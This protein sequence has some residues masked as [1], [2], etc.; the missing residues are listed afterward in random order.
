MKKGFFLSLKLAIFSILLIKSSL[1]AI[2]PELVSV[3][4]QQVNEISRL[5][6]VFDNDD[7]RADR[8]HLEDEKQ[9]ILNIPNIQATQRVLRGFNTSEFSG[10]IVFVQ[11]YKKENGVR[12]AIQLRDNVRS[13][14]QREPNRVI[15]RVENRF[16]VFSERQASESESF[17][18]R[19]VREDQLSDGRGRVHVPESDSV[20]DILENLTKSGRKRYVGK[21]ISLNVREVTVEDVLRMI[22]QASGFN[23]ILDQDIRSL[24][25]I[26]LNVNNIP[27]DQALDTVLGLN[28][29]V[30]KRN[31]SILMVTTFAKETE[32]QR[33]E[34]A[35]RQ[36]VER[37]EPLVTRVFP[38]SFTTTSE[39]RDILSEYLTEDRGTMSED[40]RTNSLIVRDVPDIIEK[41]RKI[42]EVLDT[43]TPQVLIESKIVEVTE[44]YRKEIGLR[45]GV[46]FSYDPVSASL[47]DNVGP[48]FAF[49][50]APVAAGDSFM[51]LTI[52]QF[53][54]LAD[55]RFSL[56]LLETEQKGKIISSPK[57]VTENKKTATISTT[58][59]RFFSV[60]T[61]G[62]DGQ[63][64]TSDIVE[65]EAVLN[66][67]VT[68]QVTNEGSI[69]LDISI[70]KEQFGVQDNIFIPPPQQGRNIDTS[71]LVDN[72]STIV[73]G[74]VYQ[75]ETSES[76]S[77]VPFLKDIPLL[78]WLFRTPY[79]PRV[80]KTEMIV[81]LTP[82]IVNQEEASLLTQ[83]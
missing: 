74:G 12:L 40:Q 60:T 66:L 50:S 52:S 62:T 71:V 45:E 43:Q 79:N 9:I 13:E 63:A 16:G 73:I 18:D 28:Q 14:L 48:G 56:Q 53:S 29:L 30:A 75:Y 25:P 20:E 64:S 8:V 7:I 11:P 41:M 44:N 69:S 39:M 54:R 42:V 38:L 57:V 26:T 72:G 82:R 80:D 5:E 70:T 47:G 23:I 81:F 31:G 4:F 33:Q 3:N 76:V 83:R 1:A 15:L 32:R 17:D 6:L 49:S 77:G 68:P 55:L 67:E 21:R 36:V 10:A 65:V 78:G 61:P 34:A 24:P 59:T 2:L 46:S 35:A 22:S 19:M 51:G 27:W 37:Q 58:D